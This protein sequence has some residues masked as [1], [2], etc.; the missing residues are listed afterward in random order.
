VA[1]RARVLEGAGLRGL[2][3]LH[4]ASAE[5]G[6][7]DL[8]ITTDDR[9]IRRAAKVGVDLRVRLVTPPEAAALLSEEG[10]R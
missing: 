6:G 7:A 8:L 5:V 3:A 4:I 2:D 10:S 1:A 9:L